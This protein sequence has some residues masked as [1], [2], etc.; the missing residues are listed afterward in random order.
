MDKI[1][2]NGVEYVQAGA[3]KNA[4]GLKYVIV[5]CSFAGVHS[6]FLK[7][8]DPATACAILLNSRRLWRWHGRTL[9]GLAIDGTDC[10]QKCKFGDELTEITLLGVCEVIPCSQQATQS[11]RGVGVWKND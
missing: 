2:V 10:A 5:R 9:S 1:T 7:S 8:F 6:G 4:D 3:F 11:L